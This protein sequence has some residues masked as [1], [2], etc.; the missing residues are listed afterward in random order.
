MVR[1]QPDLLHLFPVLKKLPPADL[2]RLQNG[3]QVLDLPAGQMLMQQNRQCQ[4]VPLVLSGRLRVYKLAQNGREMTL[5]R[6]GPG[7][8]C[9]ASVA[10]RISGDDFPALAEVETNARLFMIPVVL[11]EQLLAHREFWKD[12]LIL[13]MYERLTETLSV[14]EAVAFE[15]TDRRLV[16]WLL[17]KASTGKTVIRTTHE[18]I[19]VELGTAREVVSRLLG[20]MRQKGLIDMRRGQITIIE[21]D[22][23]AELLDDQE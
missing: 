21:P 18:N 19:A 7:E 10:C 3:S 1:H 22:R 16:G 8:T 17:A 23:L 9:L 6:T 2:S 11:Y 5:Y 12:F 14:L 13:S 4:H 15:R 20:D